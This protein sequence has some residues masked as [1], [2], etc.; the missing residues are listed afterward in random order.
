MMPTKERL[1]KERQRKLEEKRLDEILG[2]LAGQ[3][4][5]VDLSL[6]E[7]AIE[8]ARSYTNLVKFDEN[9]VPYR[10]VLHPEKPGNDKS[11]DKRRDN[12]LRLKGLY[13]DQWGKDGG[14]K[15]IAIAEGID[16]SDNDNILRAIQKYFKDFP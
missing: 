13:P 10:C 12:A 4:G 3:L 5:E 16:I 9:G 15:R 7:I 1:A 6:N 11:V 14:P 2:P 8:A